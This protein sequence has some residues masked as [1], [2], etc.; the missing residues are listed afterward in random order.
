MNDP[1]E[2]RVDAIEAQQLILTNQLRL[3]DAHEQQTMRRE[4]ARLSGN[5]VEGAAELEGLL[6]RL[7]KARAAAERATEL[8][9]VADAAIPPV[10][11]APRGTWV[12][13]EALSLLVIVAR[14]DVRFRGAGYYL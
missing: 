14:Q 6:R 9:A 10:Q 7:T 8:C 1:L 12:E 4:L 13:V 5:A 3:V 2:E 11:V